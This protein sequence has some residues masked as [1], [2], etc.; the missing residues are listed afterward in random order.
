MKSLFVL[1]A[2]SV[3]GIASVLAFP[4]DAR[5]GI[6][7]WIAAAFVARSA[8]RDQSS[9]GDEHQAPQRAAV[10]ASRA[11]A[12]ATFESLSGRYARLLR[13]LAAAHAE[14]GPG[15]A[16]DGRIARLSE[17]LA[18]VHWAIAEARA[19]AWAE[20]SGAT[21]APAGEFL[22]RK[23]W[24]HRCFLRLR[25]HEPSIPTRDAIDIARGFHQHS[26]WR[27]APPEAAVDFELLELELSGARVDA[28]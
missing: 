21:P 27:L 3:I 16:R 26:R 28:R 1:S 8:W 10:T 5:L 25:E 6:V 18:A 24:I 19:D 14:L 12:P 13:E 9:G 2:A 22:A 17:E 23:D 20:L 15:P 7:L 11:D 4:D